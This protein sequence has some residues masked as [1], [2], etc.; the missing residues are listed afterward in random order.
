MKVPICD[1]VL[2]N[3]PFPPGG[4]AEDPDTRV[5]RFVNRGFEGLRDEGI[6]VA[7]V[8]EAVVNGEVRAQRC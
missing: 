8:A 7:I 1:I 6:L 4:G 5:T 3:P 2:M